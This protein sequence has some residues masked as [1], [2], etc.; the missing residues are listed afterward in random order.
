MEKTKAATSTGIKK[1]K[2]GTSHGLQ[3]IKAKCSM[4]SQ[5]H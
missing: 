1:V 4:K 3:W 5:K 2:E